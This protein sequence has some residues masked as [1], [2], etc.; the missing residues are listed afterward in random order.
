MTFKKNKNR[1]MKKINLV[2]MLLISSAAFSQFSVASSPA[3]TNKWTFGGG[4]GVGFGSNSYF[5]LQVAPRVGYKV[6][7]DL[8]AGLVGSV[9]WQSSNSYKSSMFGFGPFVNYYFARSF[10]VSGNLQ[11]FFVNY[12]DKFYD[13]KNNQQ[14]TALYLGGGYMQQIGNN[15]FMQI[16]LMYN[17]LYK[18]NNSI[19][20]S[21]LIP[22]VGFV[23]GL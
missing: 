20:S 5:N 21:G 6:T 18:E 22:S 7:N 3:E 11:H 15:S 2:L 13:F 9:S 4:V 17:V 12:E 14:E 16:G 23:M 10:F 19:F 1:H 8:E